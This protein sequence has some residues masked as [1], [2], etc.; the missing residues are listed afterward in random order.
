VRRLALVAV[1]FVL[2]LVVACGDADNRGVRTP[3]HSPDPRG[4]TEPTGPAPTGARDAGADRGPDFRD[5]VAG[6]GACVAPNTVC[7][8]ACV[9]L[10]TDEAHCGACGKACVG[11]GTQCTGGVCQCTA[12]GMAYCDD[13]QGT[14][15]RDVTS[16]V[17]N[18]GSCG[19]QCDPNVYDRCENSKCLEPE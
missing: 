15:C 12:T 3:A 17:N 1:G 7:S 4:S 9:S 16:D 5:P 19:F 10:N 2:A 18:C 13:A 8:G 11:G 6:D 14:G